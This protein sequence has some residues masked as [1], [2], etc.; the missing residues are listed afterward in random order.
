MG[1][2]DKVIDKVQKLHAHAESAKKIGNEAEAQAFAA[3]VQELLTQ[4]KLSMSDVEFA[5]RDDEDPIDQAEVNLTKHG[6]RTKQVRIEWQEMLAAV[7]GR[8]SFS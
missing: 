5:R 4:Y 7:I 8:S 1:T 2:I 6:F 3:K